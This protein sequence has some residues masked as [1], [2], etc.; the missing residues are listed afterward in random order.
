MYP[1]TQYGLEA[2]VSYHRERI[3]HDMLASRRPGRHHRA[4][5]RRQRLEIVPPYGDVRA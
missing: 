3:A 2:Q 4:L 5:H 1:T